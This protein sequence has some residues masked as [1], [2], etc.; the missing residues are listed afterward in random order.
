[1]TRDLSATERELVE[2][3]QKIQAERQRL[4]SRAP[5]WF[6]RPLPPA[7]AARGIERGIERRA[8]RIIV[9]RALTPI[10]FGGRAF[11]AVSDAGARRAGI[12]EIVRDV[13]SD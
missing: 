6:A 3:Q 12:A 11:Q 13:E 10:V 1:M 4:R 2:N 5:S 7:A 8:R 9:P